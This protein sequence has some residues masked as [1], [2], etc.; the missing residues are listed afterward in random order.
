MEEGFQ[1][2]KE[3]FDK[4]VFELYLR[5]GQGYIPYMMNDALECYLVLKDCRCTGKYLKGYEE[6]TFGYLSSEDGEEIL[7]VHQGEENIFTLWFGKIQIKL[8]GYQ[9]HPIG[10]F[11]LEGK[12]QEQ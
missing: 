1:K 11:W 3:I 12:G 6:S 9:Y 7:V 4:E 5:Q 2:L 10:H 8:K